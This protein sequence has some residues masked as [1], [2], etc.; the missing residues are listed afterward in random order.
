MSMPVMGC[1]S[2]IKWPKQITASLVEQLI[3]AEKDL[4][5]AIVVFDTA[6]AEYSNGFRHDQTTF[7]LMISRLL[8]V[9]Q[10]SSAEAMLE[11]MKDENCKITEDIFLSIYR[12][13][14]RVHKPLEVIR[15]FQMMKKYNCQPT[16]KSYITVFSILVDENQLNTG[17]KFYRYMRK[18]GIPASV[19]SLNILM[20][21]L[22]KNSSTINS[23]LEI[24]TEMPKRGHIPDSYSYGT[25]I[26]GFCRVGKINEAKE[27]FSQMEANGCSPNVV[28]YTCLI[29]GLCQYNSLD[30]AI[31][32]LE[33]MKIR[34]IQPNVF[35][36]SCI[37]D[38]LCKS[39]Q[40]SRA[41]KLL[42]VMINERQVPN[43]V[44]Y[45]TLVYGLCKDG[46]LREALEVFDRMK[47]QGL[48]PDAGLY[49]KIIS[50]FCDTRRFQDAANFL[51]EM[52]LGGI[53]PN[54]VTWSLHV[55]IHNTVVQGLCTESDGNRAFQVYQSMRTRG[56]SVEEKSFV[57][58][59]DSFCR[60][61]DA[62]KA[63]RI[64]DEMVLDGCI[65]DEGA[66]K[67][68]LS[69]FWDKKK[70]WEAAKCVH[71]KLVE[72]QPC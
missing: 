7:G 49:W 56:I 47:L 66:W 18:M 4:H 3:R 62:H 12:A 14:G 33:I 2:T 13:Y 31:S 19:P 27:L 61:G 37:M 8:S 32:F 72:E 54:R 30:E 36:Y 52:V 1:R 55:K 6:T 57:L 41:M 22:C 39:G 58:L 26:N 9:N 67:A 28:T 17:L 63:S 25:L 23:A 21:A 64:L 11:R 44:T 65:P 71:K 59:L 40:S 45:S 20:K 38:G 29:R 68:I 15:V 69:G 70:V 16:Q 51:D 5:K 53:S 34:G 42:E 24:F 46:K 48:K 35:T 10:F 50:G 43:M 60:R